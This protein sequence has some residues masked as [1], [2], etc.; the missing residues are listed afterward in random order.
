MET[1]REILES[2]K[3]VPINEVLATEID[4]ECLKLAGDVVEDVRAKYGDKAEGVL[5][6]LCT[7]L[8]L[9]GIERQRPGVIER[10]TEAVKRS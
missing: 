5:S 10:I 4:D 7:L 2:K 1:V 3:V 6:S 9:C 8:V